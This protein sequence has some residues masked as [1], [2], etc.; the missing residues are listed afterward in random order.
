MD[1]WRLALCSGNTLADGWSEPCLQKSGLAGSRTRAAIHTRPFS[2]IIW[3]WMLVWLSQIGSGPQYGEGAMGLSLED[4]V[5]GSRTGGFTCVA[6]CVFGS[7]T[8][9]LSVLSSVAP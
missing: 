8:R 2:S 7:S 1:R 4:G 5:F 3:L 9:K 6:V